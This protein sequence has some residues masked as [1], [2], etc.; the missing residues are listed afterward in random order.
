MSQGITLRGGTLQQA[1]GAFSNAQVAFENA[2][3]VSVS[4]DYGSV[5][6]EEAMNQ[7]QSALQRAT[8]ASGNQASA[9]ACWAEQTNSSFLSLDARL[10]LD[11][12]IFQG[13]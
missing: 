5:V 10:G 12:N 3:M 11:T 8:R 2:G 1:A 4:A 7:I 13:S 9:N 6:V